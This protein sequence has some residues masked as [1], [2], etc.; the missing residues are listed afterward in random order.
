MSFRKGNLA[1]IENFKN[2]TSHYERDI[3]RKLRVYNF[4][5]YRVTPLVRAYKTKTKK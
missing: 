1:K 2:G 5:N 4:R 3:V